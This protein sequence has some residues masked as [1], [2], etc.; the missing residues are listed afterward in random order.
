MKMKVFVFRVT[1]V[2]SYLSEPRV[3]I[4]CVKKIISNPRANWDENIS[5]RTLYRLNRMQ[6]K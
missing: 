4:F 2:N 1:T 5:K 6:V 3:Y